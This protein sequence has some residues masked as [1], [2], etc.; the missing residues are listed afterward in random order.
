VHFFQGDQNPSSDL[1]I[2]LPPDLIEDTTP[3]T[4]PWQK[5]SNLSSESGASLANAD[6]LRYAKQKVTKR[7]LEGTKTR[8]PFSGAK[9]SLSGSLSDNRESAPAL[10]PVRGCLHSLTP[11]N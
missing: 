5:I 6:Q 11:H 10:Q 2:R 3:S 9:I 7:F 4:Q 1:D 8:A